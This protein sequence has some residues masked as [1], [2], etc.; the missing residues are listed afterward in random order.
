MAQLWH[1]II[2]ELET[3]KR[4]LLKMAQY[5]GNNISVMFLSNYMTNFENLQYTLF[6]LFCS[7]FFIQINHN[8]SPFLQNL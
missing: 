8:H 7:E 5:F 3:S 2:V 4:V 6:T 1:K